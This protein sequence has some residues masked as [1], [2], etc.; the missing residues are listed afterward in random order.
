MWFVSDD[1]DDR[2]T[3]TASATTATAIG[4]TSQSQSNP[5]QWVE[6]ARIRITRELRMGL[7][8]DV[9]ERVVGPEIMRLV[10]EM[11]KKEYGSEDK[12]W[13]YQ[14]GDFERVVV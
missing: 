4:S 6:Q 14:G 9:L 12:W 10:V 11:K 2:T 1:D 13:W 8:K 3:A 5:E 7:E